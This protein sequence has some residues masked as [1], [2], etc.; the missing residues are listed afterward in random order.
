[1]S[2]ATPFPQPNISAYRVSLPDPQADSPGRANSDLLELFQR[3]RTFQ[4][5]VWRG[6][7]WNWRSELSPRRELFR[8]SRKLLN[9]SP[10]YP[11]VARARSKSIGFVVPLAEFGG[12]EKTAYNLAGVMRDHGWSTHL[13]VFCR[14]AAQPASLIVEGFDT[15]LIFFATPASA[16][17]TKNCD[18]WARIT[19]AG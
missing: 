9:A 4:S 17:G 14:Q 2:L 11:R 6:Q 15:Q 19:R 7:A 3:M 18:I 10:V 5:T 12:V 13:F 1:M 16:I 8:V